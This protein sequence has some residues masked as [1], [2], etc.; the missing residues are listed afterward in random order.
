MLWAPTSP[1]FIALFRNSRMQTNCCLFH[2]LRTLLKVCH[3]W[4]CLLSSISNL[5]CLLQAVMGTL[6]KRHWAR[7]HGHPPETIY[8]CAVMPC[9]DKKLEASRDDFNVPGL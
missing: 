3:L 2:G 9:Y 8:H 4:N 1:T 5:S 6:V 7:Q